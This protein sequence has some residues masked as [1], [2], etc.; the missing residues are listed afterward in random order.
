M[1]VSERSRLAQ[2][3]S[4]KDQIMI[5]FFRNSLGYSEEEI[6]HRLSKA[7]TAELQNNAM[8]GFGLL[9]GVVDHVGAKIDESN[10]KMALEAAQEGDSSGAEAP[11]PPDSPAGPL[12][13][14]GGKL[15]AGVKKLRTTASAGVRRVRGALGMP[16]KSFGKSPVFEPF[17]GFSRND[18][19]FI[20]T[21]A[22]E[23]FKSTRHLDIMS[24]NLYKSFGVD[25][26]P[27]RYLEAERRVR[28]VSHAHDLFWMFNSDVFNKSLHVLPY[29]NKNYGINPFE[30]VE[31][32]QKAAG[33]SP[34]SDRTA[35]DSGQT[36]ASKILNSDTGSIQDFHPDEVLRH[37]R[38]NAKGEY[39]ISSDGEKAL[40]DILKKIGVKKFTPF[41]IDGIL[42]ALQKNGNHIGSGIDSI[43]S[44][45][46][47]VFDADPAKAD[48]IKTAL[49]DAIANNAAAASGSG[50]TSQPWIQQT[51]APK[52]IKDAYAAGTRPGE[53][54]NDAGKVIPDPAILPTGTAHYDHDLD[55]GEIH[56]NA[57]ERA[58]TP[59]GAPVATGAI[60]GNDSAQLFHR[61]MKDGFITPLDLSVSGTD[62]R[63]LHGP[64]G[65]NSAAAKKFRQSWGHRP[66]MVDEVDAA[67]NPT[68]NKV[69]E[70]VGGKPQYEPLGEMETPMWH[71]GDLGAKS[72]RWGWTDENPDTDKMSRSEQK[73]RANLTTNGVPAGEIERLVEEFKK[74]GNIDGWGSSHTG[75][76]AGQGKQ[77]VR[78]HRVGFLL[79]DP[80]NPDKGHVAVEWDPSANGGAGHYVAGMHHSGGRLQTFSDERDAT[81]GAIQGTQGAD[82]S[83]GHHGLH[84]FLT[85]LSAAAPAWSLV[86]R[87]A[88]GPQAY[89]AQQEN[90]WTVSKNGSI[91]PATGRNRLSD[92]VNIHLHQGEPDV[93]VLSSLTGLS[94]IGTGK[95]AVDAAQANQSLLR[96][97]VS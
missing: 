17:Y 78:A 30:F 10:K 39:A 96:A 34:I 22:R 44:I 94:H 58:S 74:T 80:N 86:T 62:E 8:G 20:D 66:K 97:N 72:D 32:L 2:I 48:A 47:S 75:A 56:D 90:A 87:T 73:T 6:R 65:A 46:R 81:T 68:G 89:G 84:H 52:S 79:K 60:V 53:T 37:A 54:F 33:P 64:Q 82:T 83:Y 67:G 29:L 27:A 51:K 59:Y 15:V 31:F 42:K 61:M 7:S 28:V 25:N 13:K 38:E 19:K 4:Q 3:Q 92:A 18:V 26:R 40:K 1:K 45:R 91:D 50:G 41:E 5:D 14:L 43:D 93:D 95:T 71:S 9:Q 11:P 36:L 70:A 12:E 69:Q 16:P 49:K 57:H 55:T 63:N 23:F 35:I 21:V 88:D 85:T 24:D 76:F 77:T